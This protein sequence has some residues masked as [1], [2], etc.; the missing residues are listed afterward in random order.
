MM[1]ERMEQENSSDCKSF[2]FQPAKMLPTS[3]CFPACTATAAKTDAALKA[4]S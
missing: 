3:I 4:A 2:I 1:N